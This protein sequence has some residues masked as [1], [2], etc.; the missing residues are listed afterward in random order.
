MWHLYSNQQGE[1]VTLSKKRVKDLGPA[2]WL[3]DSI[4]EKFLSGEFRY[5]DYRVVKGKLVKFEQAVIPYKPFYRI[6]TGADGDVIIERNKDRIT[7][8]SNVPVKLWVTV[9]N[10][11]TQLLL[12]LDQNSREVLLPHKGKISIFT[13]KQPLKYVYKEN[14]SS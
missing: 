9:Y 10:N 14:I 13:K 2:I 11:P 8:I 5:I 7:V 3:D 6:P 1:I 12:E 4:A